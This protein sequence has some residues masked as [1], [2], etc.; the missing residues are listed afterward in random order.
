MIC[1]SRGMKEAD[2]SI[3]RFLYARMYRHPD[4][5]VA[6]GPRPTTCCATCSGASRP[7]RS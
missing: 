5:M 7:S 3:K 2:A 1:F 4:V 6:S